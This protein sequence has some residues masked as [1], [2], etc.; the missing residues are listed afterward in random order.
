MVLGVSLAR[1]AGLVLPRHRAENTRTQHGPILVRLL[2]DEGTASVM[3]CGTLGRAWE[4]PGELGSFTFLA[5]QAGLDRVLSTSDVA[6]SIP[7]TVNSKT[8]VGTGAVSK[9]GAVGRVLGH[10]ACANPV[11]GYGQALPG[12][13]HQRGKT[14]RLATVR[15]GALPLPPP[16]AGGQPGGH[17]LSPRALCPQHS[18]P[19]AAL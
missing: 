11:G 9:H 6:S 8:G 14:P 7:G 17:H 3:R 13:L 4:E 15:T 1:V 5:S 2:G 10:W 18:R 19:W 12:P 16:L